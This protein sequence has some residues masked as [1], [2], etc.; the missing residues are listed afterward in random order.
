MSDKTQIL[1]RVTIGN[2]VQLFDIDDDVAEHLGIVKYE[3]PIPSYLAGEVASAYNA[4]L[5]YDVENWQKY[6]NVLTDGEEVVATE[7]A[8]GT[9]TGIGH[10]PGLNHPDAPND[11]FVSSKGLS[12]KGLFLKN[13]VR[14]DN[15]LYVQV[16]RRLEADGVIE[17]IKVW[18][19][20]EPVY[21]LGE[22]FG[23]GV[24]D[25]T[26]GQTGKTFM[27][28]DVYIGVPGKGR[29]LGYDEL[30]KLTDELGL[31][32]VPLLYRGPFDVSA[33]QKVR[34]GKET[35]SG[36]EAHI[37]EGVVIKPVIE[38]TDIEIGRAQ[39]KMVSPDYLLRKGNAT[40]FN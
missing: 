33:L 13:N 22:T 31:A 40:E 34:D 30:V 25:L 26:Y 39:L 37:R 32:R 20:G 14:N 36:T 7:K 19:N 12:E 28:F 38:R 15:N 9:W 16:M 27:V 23:A 24:Q 1:Y 10:Y 29:Y 2:D 5:K 11:L 4:T 18:A 21:V 35:I 6:P 17:R 3:P 8:H